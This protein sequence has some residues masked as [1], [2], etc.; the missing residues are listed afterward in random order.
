MHWCRQGVLVLGEMSLNNRCKKVGQYYKDKRSYRGVR[1]QEHLWKSLQMS[2]VK[3]KSKQVYK[4]YL[5]VISLKSSS[6][7]LR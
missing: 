2:E 6:D 3:G 7:Y 4:Y 1:V 5:Q